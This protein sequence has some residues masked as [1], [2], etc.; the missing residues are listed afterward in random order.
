M[1]LDEPVRIDDDHDL[2]LLAA[3]NPAPH[4]GIARAFGPGSRMHARVLAAVDRE[5]PVQAR[6]RAPSRP[7]VLRGGAV[8]AAALVAAA[9]VTVVGQ[10]EASA[11][12]ALAVPLPFARGTHAAARAFLLKDAALLARGASRPAGSGSVL[13]T[14]V[15]DYSPQ[16]A[17]RH[18][19]TSATVA[20]TVRQIWY[21]ADGSSQVKEFSQAQDLIGGDV[22]GPQAI[23]GADHTGWTNWPDVNAGFPSDPAQIAVRLSAGAQD[24]DASTRLDVLKEEAAQHL[25]TGTATVAQIAGIYQVLAG[26]SDV[27]DAGVVTDRIGRTGHAIGLRSHEVE[28]GNFDAT[29]LII[30]P[31]TGQVLQTEN[32]ATRPPSALKLPDKPWVQSYD[33]IRQS[34]PVAAKGAA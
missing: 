24:V 27:F 31:A 22:G 23:A 21:A 12:P 16:V 8:A 13:F 7:W 2:R 11:S 33:I 5:S 20:T 15:Q 4:A 26:V 30:D 18:G 19:K 34:R 6:R 32:V 3:I 14:E 1:N 28:A 9:S 17:H 29:Y 10:H 25:Q